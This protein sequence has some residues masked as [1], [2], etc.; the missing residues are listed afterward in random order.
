M[1]SQP[2]GGPPAG[3]PGI[4]PWLLWGGSS[5]VEISGAGAPSS[6]LARIEYHRPETWRFFFAAQLLDVD[7]PP[8]ADVHFQVAFDILPGVG[9]ANFDSSNKTN[10]LTP[11]QELTF[12]LMNFKVPAGF[13]PVGTIVTKRWTT[14]VRSPLLDDE[15]ATSHFPI[16]TIC[17]KNFQCQ[18]NIT[19]STGGPNITA[20]FVLT[21]FFTPNVH[22]RP[23]WEIH[24][25]A[26]ELAGK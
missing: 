8:L 12:C 3:I 20:H 17:A 10:L 24:R 21:A 22:V 5:T 13:N 6:Q 14:S 1:M 15:D 11:P 23:D 4:E 7:T 2:V 16:D 25:F 18:A 19:Q 9:R 26:G